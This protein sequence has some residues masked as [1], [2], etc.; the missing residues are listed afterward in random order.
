MDY[1]TY[2][3][4]VLTQDGLILTEIPESEFDEA[5]ANLTCMDG[6]VPMRMPHGKRVIGWFNEIV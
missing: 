3:I 2:G 5:V 6:D 1:L 4:L